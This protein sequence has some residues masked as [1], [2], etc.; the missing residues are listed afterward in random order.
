MSSILTSSTSLT[1]WIVMTDHCGADQ[2]LQ[3][4]VEQDERQRREAEALRANLL[5][6]KA[7]ARARQA[8]VVS[9]ERQSS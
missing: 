5:R 6:R 7:Q 2:T 1:T 8:Q 4:L 3:T 9:G